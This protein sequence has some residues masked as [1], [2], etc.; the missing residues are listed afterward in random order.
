MGKYSL[1]QGQLTYIYQQRTLKKPTS[2]ADIA[3]HLHRRKATVMEEGKRYLHEIEIKHRTR[4][5]RMKD[6]WRQVKAI[7][8]EFNVPIAKAR[9]MRSKMYKLGWK[10]VMKWKDFWDTCKQYGLT[11]DERKAYKSSIEEEY[12]LDTF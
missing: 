6:Y 2:W 8:K 10:P 5:L 12:E 3:R 4:S 11:K 9:E 7:A 1:T